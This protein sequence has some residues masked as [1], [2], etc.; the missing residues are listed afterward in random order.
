[1]YT[2]PQNKVF[3]SSLLN[4]KLD[5]QTQLIVLTLFYEQPIDLS[6]PAE[7]YIINTA[8]SDMLCLNIPAHVV[9]LMLYLCGLTQR[10]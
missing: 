10:N 6:G 5:Y 3:P 7:S 1:M 9:V 4:L 2:S 8:L